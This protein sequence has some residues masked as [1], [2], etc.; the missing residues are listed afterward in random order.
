MLD[1]ADYFDIPLTKERLEEYLEKISSRFRRPQ[2]VKVF[3]DQTGALNFETRPFKRLEDRQPLMAG[4]AKE[5]VDSSNVFLFH[6]TTHREVYQSARKGYETL[7]DVLLYNEKGELTE[8]TIGNLV[9]ELEGQLLTPPITCGVLAGTFRAH[10]L[11]TIQ[12]QESLI[13]VDQLDRC[14][15]IFRVN[16]VRGWQDVRIR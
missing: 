4:L 15:R 8:F 6:K 11:E 13:R 3:L 1:S 9:V 16:S 5:P 2:R 7:D 12:L 10:L 14:A